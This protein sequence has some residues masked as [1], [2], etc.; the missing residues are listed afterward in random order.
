MKRRA[1]KSANAPKS[2]R[3]W[4][5]SLDFSRIDFTGFRSVRGT[6]DAVPFHLFYHTSGAIITYAKPPL[7]HGN[8][9]LLGLGYELHGLIVHLIVFVL[10][11]GAAL[12]LFLGF[13]D[14]GAV[15]R[16]RLPADELDDLFDLLVGDEGAV[17]ARE[18]RR[19]GREEQHIAFAQQALGADRV[20]DRPGIDA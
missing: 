7:N 6:D 12:H 10:A 13:E 2:L 5:L 19:P 17:D 8:R 3:V 4:G 16:L 15:A 18:P 14:L 1:L 9:G 20:E 11:A